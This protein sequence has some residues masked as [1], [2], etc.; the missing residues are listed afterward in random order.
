MSQQKPSRNNSSR[1][2]RPSS[3]SSRRPDMAANQLS[4]VKTAFRKW[5]MV[6]AFFGVLFAI[7]AGFLVLKYWNP[8]YEARQ[9]VRVI[10]DLEYLSVLPDIHK[11]R[12]NPKSQLAPIKSELLL[13][14]VLL[15]SDVSRTTKAT[16]YDLRIKELQSKIRFSP[17]G[18]ELYSIQCRDENPKNAALVAQKVTE[19]FI[20]KFFVNYR[21]D[22]IKELTDSL[23]REI[24]T[25]TEK[26]EGLD[27]RIASLK[28]EASYLVGDAGG[29]VSDID[30]DLLVNL[31]KDLKDAELLQTQLEMEKS[32]F[33]AT[34][35]SDDPDQQKI[36]QEDVDLLVDNHP[37]VIRGRDYLFSLENEAALNQDRARPIR[38]KGQF[39]IDRQRDNLARTVKR[40]GEKVRF[41]LVRKAQANAKAQLAQV[42]MRI[43]RNQLRI[44][45]S[46]GDI[47]ALTGDRLGVLERQSRYND[48]KN[49]KQKAESSLAKWVNAR[50]KIRST[51]ISPIRVAI[52]GSKE[53]V[54]PT[55][56][57]EAYPWKLLAMSTLGAMLVPFVF[58][59]LWEFKIGRISDS[60]QIQP[61]VSVSMLGEVADLP[62]RVRR[63]SPSKQLMRQVRLYEESVNTVSAAMRFGHD[64]DPRVIAICSACSNEGK[65]TLASQYA[66]SIARTSDMKTLLID[67]DLR[68]PS[69]HRVFDAELDGGLVDTI[70][71]QVE[72]DEAVVESGIDNLDVL[73]AGRL[74][75]NPMRCFAGDQWKELL[76]RALDKYS[77]IIVD[78]PPLLA[79]AETV[80][81]AKACDVALLCV[82]RDVSRQSS[83]RQAFGRLLAADVNVAGYVFGG[84]P[85]KSYAYKYGSY[86]YT[87]S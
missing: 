80:A 66:M 74:R 87:L 75:S 8:V 22:R 63:R 2:R 34:V 38:E 42:N 11:E 81:I 4:M 50:E 56:P 17:A 65:T 31:R 5:G 10:Q 45:S 60:G 30:G 26:I 79:A 82:M 69:V 32:V 21:A 19:V 33:E 23:D 73:V 25:T 40:V 72:L 44:D 1:R 55:E 15:D 13:R 36:L 77:Y 64:D 7:G 62:K 70:G 14:E 83:V 41:D 12:V 59:L 48:L 3:A 68:S 37:D 9:F 6:S 18:G 28:K 29:L 85:Q 51:E 67:G 27:A 86:G 47:K 61:Q 49:E 39:A 76:S 20:D 46:N 78:T 16:T 43:L 52:A 24:K 84:V 71:N 58:P 35:N 57:L 53:V 54:V